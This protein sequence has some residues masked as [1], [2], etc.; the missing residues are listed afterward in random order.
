[1]AR[2]QRL[3]PEVRRAPSGCVFPAMLMDNFGATPAR[4]FIRREAFDKVGYFDES[5]GS[6]VDY[7][8]SLRIA[9]NFP[10]L[11]VPGA[12]MVYT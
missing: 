5:L 6:D 2:E 4:L 3:E 8:M 7:D 10:F 12:V 9:F 11:F 1:M